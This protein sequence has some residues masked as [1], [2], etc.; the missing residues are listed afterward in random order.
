M[1]C[2]SCGKEIKEGA[3][4]CPECGAAQLAAQNY[5]TPVQ[6]PPY[7]LMC[8]LGLVI[9]GIS[10]LINFWGLVGIGGTIVSIIGFDSCKKKQES[11]KVL[12]IIGMALGAA[13]ILY[14]FFVL[15][16]MSY[17]IF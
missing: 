3:G 17:Y 2:V 13:S 8:I 14:G 1:Y 4:F 7:N 12:A 11:G 5:P 10:I 9:S 15:M 6:R 16:E